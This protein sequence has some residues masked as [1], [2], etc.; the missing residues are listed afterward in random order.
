[1]LVSCHDQPGINAPFVR[2]HSLN[3][4]CVSSAILHYESMVVALLGYQC[5]INNNYAIKQLSLR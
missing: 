5:D 3:R 2:V 1:M 4:C